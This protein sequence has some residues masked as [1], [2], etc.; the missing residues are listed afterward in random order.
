MKEQR[1]A[2]KALKA[3]PG[4][5]GAD[6]PEMAGATGLPVAEVL[7]YVASL[8]KYGG[9]LE[10][11]KAGSYYRYTSGATVDQDRSVTRRSRRPDAPYEE[12]TWPR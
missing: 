5:G 11:P 1:R 10:V 3:Q 2:I 8:K 4:G 7:W 12:R 6:V 9:I